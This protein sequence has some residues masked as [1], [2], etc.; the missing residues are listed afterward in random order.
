MLSQWRTKHLL[1]NRSHCCVQCRSWQRRRG[2][3]MA[4]RAVPNANVARRIRLEQ[5]DGIIL[6]YAIFEQ[7]TVTALCIQSADGIRLLPHSRYGLYRWQKLFETLTFRLII[8]F[9]EGNTSCWTVFHLS[10]DFPLNPKETGPGFTGPTL[11]IFPGQLSSFTHEL[12]SLSKHCVCSVWSISD[13]VLLP[14]RLYAAIH[15]RLEVQKRWHDCLFI[16]AGK[17]S[18][19]ST[20][21]SDGKKRKEKWNLNLHQGGSMPPATLDGSV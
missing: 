1:P 2:I 10:Q 18:L 3:W 6:K 17:N 19:D 7:M 12:L 15:N 8:L 16:S 11:G 9:E 20:L 5:Q 14:S 4:N 21:Q 13:I